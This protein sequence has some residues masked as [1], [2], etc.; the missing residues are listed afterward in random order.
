[1][2][3]PVFRPKKKGYLFFWE[4]IG[5]FPATFI[6]MSAI[7]CYSQ[8]SV[9]E[10]HMNVP[11]FVVICHCTFCHTHFAHVI[12][13][14]FF[15]TLLYT[16]QVWQQKF[17]VCLFLQE[18]SIF[19]MTHCFYKLSRS[20]ILI[21][22]FLFSISL[23]QFVNECATLFWVNHFCF[24]HNHIFSVIIQIVWT[25]CAKY[26]SNVPHNQVSVPVHNWVSLV[27]FAKFILQSV[28]LLYLQ[29]CVANEKWMLHIF[30]ATLISK[31]AHSVYSKRVWHL[32][33]WMCQNIRSVYQ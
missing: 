32:Y 25:V 19:F 5:P 27:F 15:G 18:F 20:F 13:H 24:W 26:F 14:I 21:W 1:M 8:Q 10:S 3:V 16:K 12:I 7:I 23:C 28:I 6:L 30:L 9:P 17:W 2:G 29:Q 31:L 33:T 4:K 22:V 11:H